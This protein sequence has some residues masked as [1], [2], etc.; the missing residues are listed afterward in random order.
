MKRKTK[1]SPKIEKIAI[2]K[3][4]LKMPEDILFGFLLALSLVFASLFFGQVKADIESQ[5]QSVS[6][7]DSPAK[8]EKN[9]KRMVSDYPIRK[10][11][12]FIAGQDKK[13]AAYLVAIAKKESDWGK[14]SP[15]KGGKECFNY[16]GYKGKYNRNAAGYSCFKSPEQAVRVVG[17]RLNNLIAQRVDT[18]R[19]MVLWKCGSA[20]SARSSTDAA[21]WVSDVDLYYRKV[22]N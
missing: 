15:K 1:R 4:E 17:K 10:M 14:Y 7:N 21:K 13:V 16:W 22:Y 11:T 6:Q 20:C 9:I 19:E 3:H 8:L 2:C 18:P 12:P 5:R